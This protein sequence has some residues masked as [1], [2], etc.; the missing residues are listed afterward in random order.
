LVASQLIDGDTSGDEGNVGRRAAVVAEQL[1]KGCRDEPGSWRVLVVDASVPVC[2]LLGVHSVSG[3]C[4]VGVAVGN[5]EAR[6]AEL[7]PLVAVCTPC[8]SVAVACW[9]WWPCCCNQ[10]CQRANCRWRYRVEGLVGVGAD[11]VDAY[12]VFVALIYVRGCCC[13][14]VVNSR[15]VS[16]WICGVVDPR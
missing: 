8:W 6:E 11:N 12:V 9:S 3:E 10:H 16:W 7:A 13:W 2:V 15:S 14:V 5:V 4:R 1:D